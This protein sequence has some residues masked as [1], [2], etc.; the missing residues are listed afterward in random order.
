MKI[1]SV[2]LKYASGRPAQNGYRITS[3][4]KNFL[5]VADSRREARKR[6]ER[7]KHNPGTPGLRTAIKKYREFNNKDPRVVLTK[8]LD[9]SKPFIRIGR[10]P[11]LTYTS[12]KEGKLT[13]YKHDTKVMPTMYA[14]PT[15]RILVITGGSWKLRDWFY[16]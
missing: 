7:W 4:G 3:G 5:V 16:D 6:I 2:T 1:E 10:V 8:Q 9:L 15:K 13:Y 11:L 12:D 14:H